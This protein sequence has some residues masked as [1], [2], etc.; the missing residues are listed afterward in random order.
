MTKSALKQ[1]AATAKHRMKNGYYQDE[2]SDK[3]LLSSQEKEEKR[4]YAKIVEMNASGED[5]FNPL[6]RLVEIDKYEKMNAIQKER[7][8]LILSNT[9]LKMLNKY[10]ESKKISY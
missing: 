10:L 4:V 3:S 5:V 1:L 8:I 2:C 9:Y 6:G 7:Y